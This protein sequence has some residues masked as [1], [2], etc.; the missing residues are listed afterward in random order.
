M[1]QTKRYIDTLYETSGVNLLDEY[2]D[3]DYQYNEWR[4]HIEWCE[5]SNLPSPLSYDNTSTYVK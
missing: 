4:Q 2:E 3:Y 1:S 5:Y